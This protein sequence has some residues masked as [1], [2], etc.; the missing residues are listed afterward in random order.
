MAELNEKNHDLTYGFNLHG[1]LKNHEGFGMFR[2]LTI[3]AHSIGNLMRFAN[4]S[5]S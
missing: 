5:D 4:H 3:E 1:G 2:S